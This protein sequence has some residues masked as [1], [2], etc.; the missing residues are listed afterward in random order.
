MPVIYVSCWVNAD[1]AGKNAGPAVTRDARRGALRN[2]LNSARNLRP[3][4]EARAVGEKREGSVRDDTTGAPSSLLVKEPPGSGNGY[5]KVGTASA[6]TGSRS[7]AALSVGKR[8]IEAFSE[9]APKQLQAWRHQFMM[10][11][12]VQLHAVKA[13]NY[14]KSIAKSLK[15]SLATFITASRLPQMHNQSA[16]V[17]IILQQ[18]GTIEDVVVD[19]ETDNELSEVLVETIDWNVL[20]LPASFGLA[21]RVVKLTVSI[22]NV[23][24]ICVYPELQNPYR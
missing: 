14:Y 4:S 12:E 5:P 1:I 6:D 3:A 2:A 11:V 23:G 10:N 7:A 18:D 20:P 22:D 9:Y 19:S 16:A 17:E 15:G 21:E 24:N 8:D 13:R